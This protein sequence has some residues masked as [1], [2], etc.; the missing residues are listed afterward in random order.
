MNGE[1]QIPVGQAQ[2]ENTARRII[3]GRAV[4]KNG[5]VCPFREDL[6]SD[7]AGLAFI[8][9][10]AGQGHRLASSGTDCGDG[11]LRRRL[12]DAR[13]AAAGLGERQRDSRS[14]AAACAGDDGRST[15]EGKGGGKGIGHRD[16]SR[17]KDSAVRGARI[18]SEP[19]C[20]AI[21]CNRK[22]SRFRQSAPRIRCLDAG[23]RQQK[24]GAR[25]GW[26]R[27]R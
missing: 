25:P 18:S 14:D 15:F 10:V 1:N 26:R 27:R 2:F 7:R 11:R 6:I 5:H 16:I 23:A 22:N 8:R 12:V 13:D 24:V 21:G 9:H 20:G 17:L 4:Y 3:V 19:A